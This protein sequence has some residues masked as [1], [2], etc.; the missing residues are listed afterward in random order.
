MHFQ[1]AIGHHGEVRHHVVFAKEGA[2]RSHHLRDIGV[3]TLHQFAEFVLRLPAPVP[4]ILK[5]SDLR[6]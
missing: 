5:R 1:Q 2:Q 6:V 3:A 4:G